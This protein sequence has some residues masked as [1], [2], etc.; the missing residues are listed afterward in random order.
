ME[1]IRLAGYTEPE[2]LA[3]ARQFLIKKQ[4]EANGLKPEHI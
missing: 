1:I 2:K 4:T 3:I